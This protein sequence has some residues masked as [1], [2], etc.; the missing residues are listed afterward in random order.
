MSKKLIVQSYPNNPRVMKAQLVGLLNGV[1]LQYADGFEFGKTNKADSFYAVNPFGQVPTAFTED[2]KEGV[3]ESNSIARYVA[4][5]GESTHALYGKNA[6]EASRID[7]FLDVEISLS[8]AASDWFSPIM[9]YGTYDEAK[10]NASKERVKKILL[11]FERH[12]AHHQYLVGESISLADIVLFVSSL[13]AFVA[14]YDQEFLKDL[15]HYKAWHERISKTKEFE[16][17]VA[18]A[19]AAIKERVKKQ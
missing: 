12:L 11:G 4:R 6:L 15:P 8:T 7:A 13:F 17:A 2:G 18:G 5:L 14:I 19:T 3:F 16:H 10:T 9:G 1:T